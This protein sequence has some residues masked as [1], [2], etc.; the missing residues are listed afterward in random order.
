MS[1][2]HTRRVSRRRFLSG[3]TLAGVAGLLGL[4]TRRAAAEPPPETTKL[5]LVHAPSMC[6][7]PLFVAEEFLQGEGF[8]DVEYIKK[9]GGAGSAKALASG[10]AHISMLF[11]GPTLINLDMED[12]IVILA[13]VH[14]G[15]FELFG[16]DRVHAIRDLKGKTVAVNELGS[17]AHVFLASMVAYVGLAPRTDLQWAIHPFTESTRLLAEGKIDAVLALPPQ[18]QELRARQIGRVVVNSMIDRP[19]SQYFCCMATGNRE[20][21]RKHPI[22]TMRAL[23]AILKAADLCASEPERVAGVLIDKGY[24]TQRDY[25]LQTLKD[26]PYDR[27]R[28]YDAEDTVRFYALRLHEAG[29]IKSTPQKLIAQGTDWRFLNELKKELKG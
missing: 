28:K 18:P 5:K 27:S 17:P 14:V 29:M 21:V 7:A 4:H 6:L 13:G 16:T 11:S 15:C 26:I 24:T 2:Q 20:F 8:A 3:I 25:T 12:P 22:A 9:A 10:E 19:W 1:T 23:R